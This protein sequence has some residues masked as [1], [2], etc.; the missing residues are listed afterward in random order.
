MVWFFRATAL[1]FVFLMTTQGM[2][3]LRTRRSSSH[4]PYRVIGLRAGFSGLL[5]AAVFLVGRREG[6]LDLLFSLGLG[7][8]AVLHSVASLSIVRHRKRSWPEL[9]ATVGLLA[10]GVALLAVWVIVYEHLN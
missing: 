1:C 6:L 2:R 8:L 4:S 5:V 3:S 7:I 9:P 10:G